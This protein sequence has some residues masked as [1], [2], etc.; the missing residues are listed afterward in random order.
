MDLVYEEPPCNLEE[1]LQLSFSFINLQKFLN[2]ISNNNKEFYL[3]IS[4]IYSRLNEMDDIKSE[5]SNLS[6]K[7][8]IC[9]N[10]FSEIE[11]Q[12]LVQQ[13][14]FTDIDLKLAIQS[15]VKK[16]SNLFIII[17]KKRIILIILYTYLC[18]NKFLF[19]IRHF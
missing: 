17:N 3:K 18:L 5:V 7:L 10:K 15:N 8:D 19:K 14:K 11:N 6:N 2:S 1:I 16:S 12:I 4:D 9:V 13:Q